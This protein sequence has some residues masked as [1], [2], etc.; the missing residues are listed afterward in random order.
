MKLSLSKPRITAADVKREVRAYLIMIFGL[1][2]YSFAWT[3]LLVPAEVA[4]GGVGGVGALVFYATGIPLG[5]TYMVVN[6]F[7]LAFG[8]WIL[9]PRFGAKTIFGVLF[10]SAALTLLQEVLPPDLMGLA[11]DKLLSA[12][13]GGGIAG[14]GVG[15]CF[16]VGGSTGG[17]DILAMIINKY[18]NV[19]LGKLIMLMDVVIVG[20]AYIVLR[21]LPAVVYG[22]VTMF[23]M[24]TAVD[25]VLSG[26]KSSSQIMVFSQ[27]YA[28]IAER[29]M[30]DVN[31]GVT[32]LDATG[33]YSKSP[34]KVV[35]VICRRGEAS[36]IYRIIKETDP[37]AFIT[38]ASVMGVFGEGFDALKTK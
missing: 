33:A 16:S 1:L 14:A 2:L 32:I 23:T 3:A 6:V 13:L 26:S 7:L 27:K 24:G 8:I 29:I 19:S 15:L 22:Y 11:N 31:R 34:Q 9:G 35:M 20:S 21:D 28:E 36:D 25:W 10:N 17:T 37:K 18:R 38:Q 4:G 12:I 5:V 30:C